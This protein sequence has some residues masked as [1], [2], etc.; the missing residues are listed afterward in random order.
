MLAVLK[1]GAPE[2]EREVLAQLAACEELENVKI[3][4]RATGDVVV[5]T[6]KVDCYARKLVAERAARR[7][8]GVRAV[9]DRIEIPYGAV[10]GWRDVDIQ[11]AAVSAL[12]AHFLL[13]P[14]RIEVVVDDGV[15]FL[16][17]RVASEGERTE[18]ERVVTPI[19]NVRGL[20]DHLVVF[21][22]PVRKFV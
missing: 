6:G 11:R 19:P 5:L 3:M 21:D 2:L 22:R 1:P 13:G 15:V 9:I 8:P 10:E 4:V 16:S 14:R 7:V 20:R 12:H 17:G 18:A